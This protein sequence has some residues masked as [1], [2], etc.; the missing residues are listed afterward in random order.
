MG[1]RPA[2]L[3]FL[4][5]GRSCGDKVTEGPHLAASGSFA[6]SNTSSVIHRVFDDSL[7]ALAAQHQPDVD[8]GLVGESHG[9]LNSTSNAVFVTRSV[10][11]RLQKSQTWT[12]RVD[13]TAPIKAGFESACYP[14]RAD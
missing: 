12:L 6:E 10:P 8:V 11:C 7:I 1:T 5:A 14:T 4:V 2:S 9:S 13:A 3:E